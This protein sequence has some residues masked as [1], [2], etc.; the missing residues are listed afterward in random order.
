MYNI[1][2]FFLVEKHYHFFFHPYLLKQS[3][4][5]TE[6][7]FTHLFLILCQLSQPRHV[8]KTVC[9]LTVNFYNRDPIP[10][11]NNLKKLFLFEKICQMKLKC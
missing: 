5:V 9:I 11:F 2:F 8:V 1:H 3:I 7:I 4:Q 10:I 6:Y